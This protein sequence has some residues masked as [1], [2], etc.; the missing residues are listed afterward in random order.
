MLESQL[1]SIRARLVDTLHTTTG[2][3]STKSANTFASS[4]GLKRVIITGGSSHNA[5]IQQLVADVL[6]LPVYIADGHG[7]G[8]AASGGALL[9][10]YAWWKRNEEASQTAAPSSAPMPLQTDAHNLGLGSISP[11]TGDAAAK[12]V[13][14]PSK[15]TF[16]EMRKAFGDL[17]VDQVAVPSME[18]EKLYGQI[19]ETSFRACENAIVEGMSAPSKP[20]SIFS[21][22]SF[23]FLGLL[24]E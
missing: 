18:N 22:L 24:T 8:S 10:K 15:A 5:V 20:R 13:Q 7:G 1:L 16:E 6:G 9:A 4:A 23:P 14:S 11:Q 19:V 12:T 2:T 3:G 17:E 21:Y